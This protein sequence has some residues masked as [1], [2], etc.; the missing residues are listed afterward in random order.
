MPHETSLD[1]L[2]LLAPLLFAL[3]TLGALAAALDEA[4]R[5]DAPGTALVEAWVRAHAGGAE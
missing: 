4:A 3:M 2:R 1:M 5:R